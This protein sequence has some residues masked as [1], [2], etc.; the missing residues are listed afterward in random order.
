MQTESNHTSAASQV[1]KIDDEIIG[2]LYAISLVSKRLARNL[3]VLSRQDE[4]SKE[5][6]RK[7]EWAR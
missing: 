6:R 3:A 1:I 4:H 7:K 5:R 2:V